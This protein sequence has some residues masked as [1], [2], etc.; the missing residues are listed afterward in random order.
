MVPGP[1]L[2][3]VVA[4]RAAHAVAR[5]RHDRGALVVRLVAAH[6]PADVG[7]ELVPH[8]FEAGAVALRR[9]GVEKLALAPNARGDKVIGGLAEDRSPLVAV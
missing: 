2:H 4:V 6:P 7:A 8:P 1:R 3:D 9:D 5:S